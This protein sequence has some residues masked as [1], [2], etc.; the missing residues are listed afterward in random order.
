[1]ESCKVSDVSD[2]SDDVS[3]L[4]EVNKQNME[5]LLDALYGDE[6]LRGKLMNGFSGSSCNSVI[7]RRWNIFDNFETGNFRAPARDTRVRASFEALVTLV[8]RYLVR[9]CLIRDDSPQGLGFEPAYLLDLGCGYDET[10]TAL[11]VLSRY[12]GIDFSNDIL[13]TMQCRLAQSNDHEFLLSRDTGPTVY[14]V[15]GDLRD[16]VI[17][18]TKLQ[19]NSFDIVTAFFSVE[20][21]ANNASSLDCMMDTAAHYVG[22]GGILTGI[23]VD[24]AMMLNIILNVKP[25]AEIAKLVPAAAFPCVGGEAL[26]AYGGWTAKMAVK[27]KKIRN[28]RGRGGGTAAAAAAASTATTRYE[29]V[30]FVSSDLSFRMNTNDYLDIVE[31]RE[32]PRHGLRYEMKQFSRYVEGKRNYPAN[33]TVPKDTYDYFSWHSQYLC[34]VQTME[35]AASRYGMRLLEVKN[36]TEI[37]C[38]IEEDEPPADFLEFSATHVPLTSGNGQRTEAQLREMWL[39]LGMYCIFSFIKNRE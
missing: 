12:V 9:K 33:L 19:P 7:R 26:S 37:I 24:P 6:D 14:Y 1:M 15:K 20:R 27:Y 8:K 39:L 35:S 2:V 11:P 13:K 5:T 38:E 31:R 30:M 23:M 36:V 16:R 18:A 34:P 21:V 22:S 25:P 17:D 29:M 3:E 28:S 32:V 4:S 10:L